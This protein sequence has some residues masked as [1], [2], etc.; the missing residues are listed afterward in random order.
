V[1]PR[2]IRAPAR[3]LGAA[4]LLALAS[5]AARAGDLYRWVTEDGRVEIGTNPPLGA[6]VEPWNPAQEAVAQPTA[7]PTAQPAPPA[8]PA[9]P[10][11]ATPPGS[12]SHGPPGVPR[13]RSKSRL[14][15]T[16]STEKLAAMKAAQKISVL[17]SQIAR[18][19]RKLEELEATA[20]AYSQ[21]TCRSQEAD[22]LGSDCL[23]SSFHRDAE[24]ARTQQELEEKEQKLADLEQRAR[25][26]ASR[27][28]CTPASAE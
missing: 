24:I 17:E 5:T 15:E 11:H 13:D 19:G 16:C 4:L 7:Q 8:A 18:L 26:L 12:R 25:G 20:L 6:S 1:T 2:A 28:E 9:P 10:A 22:G 23:T 3:V 14:D 21:T 27:P